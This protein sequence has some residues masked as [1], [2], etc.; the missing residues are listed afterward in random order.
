MRIKMINTEAFVIKA[1]K[2]ISVMKYF[3]QQ[4]DAMFLLWSS[5]HMSALEVGLL[6]STAYF[7]SLRSL[8]PH[9]SASTQAPSALNTRFLLNV[10]V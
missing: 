5:R 1:E 3:D 4:F 7:Q 9:H 6:K 8:I 2:M 10:C